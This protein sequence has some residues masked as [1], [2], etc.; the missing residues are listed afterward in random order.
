MSKHDNDNPTPET[1]AQVVAQYRVVAHMARAL[2][3]VH[4]DIAGLMEAGGGLSL[5]EMWGER[6]A[7]IMDTLGNI[8]N[9]MD[10]VSEDDEWVNPIFA[11]AHRR[12]PQ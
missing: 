9:G 10:A 1:V 7:S 4:E 5:T 11:E 3:Q 2:A 6:S 12:W 8:L